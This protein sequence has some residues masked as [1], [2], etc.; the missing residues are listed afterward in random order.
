MN[1]LATLAEF[2]PSVASSIGYPSV[3]NLIV[4]VLA[5][6]VLF[7]VGSAGAKAL[8][9][10]V[11]PMPA[12]GLNQNGNNEIEN[13]EDIPFE[14]EDDDLDEFED[15]QPLL[16]NNPNPLNNHQNQNDLQE[17][18]D[19]DEGYQDAQP[20]PPPPDY[21]LSIWATDASGVSKEMRLEND[22]KNRLN[23]ALETIRIEAAAGHPELANEQVIHS[24]QVSDFQKRT[25]TYR[26]AEGLVVEID[27]SELC[28]RDGGNNPLDRAFFD[29]INLYKEIALKQRKE[30]L[31]RELKGTVE[32]REGVYYLRVN[33][34]DDR[35]LTA[36]EL[37]KIYGLDKTIELA[38]KRIASPQGLERISAQQATFQRMNNELIKTE[39]IKKSVFYKPLEK[40]K[41]IPTHLWNLPRNTY[42]AIRDCRQRKQPTAFE[43][44]TEAQKTARE[45]AETA[46]NHAVNDKI[47]DVLA[48]LVPDIDRV[49]L[50]ELNRIGR[51]VD[52][53]YE[54]QIAN[55]EK[56]KQLLAGSDQIKAAINE[57]MQEFIEQHHKRPTLQD[58]VAMTD[59]VYGRLDNA[60]K[61]T[62]YKAI[63]NKLDPARAIFP[64]L[65]DEAAYADELKHLIDDYFNLD[66][67]KIKAY[68]KLLPGQDLAQVRNQETEALKL[69]TLK[70]LLEDN[71]KKPE[72]ETKKREYLTP[73]F[74]K[75]VLAEWK[76]RGDAE[77]KKH[78]QLIN[79]QE[80]HG[81]LSRNPRLA[82]ELYSYKDSFDNARNTNNIAEWKRAA[83]ACYNDL[84]KLAPGQGQ[85]I[86]EL[87]GAYYGGLA[88]EQFV[89][90]KGLILRKEFK[91]D[92]GSITG[93][94][95][96]VGAA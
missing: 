81:I 67:A 51:E 77:Q 3:S 39:K 96:A 13:L 23:E 40:A 61:I 24:F 86:V 31:G 36:Q 4:G 45:N 35:R 66:K 5:L 15:V 55:K 87:I 37:G 79:S 28:L 44:F 32:N 71:V 8:M 90:E 70:Q 85:F 68:E 76:E 56:Y 19:G 12:Q 43:T 69:A 91:Q 58:E 34:M 60:R 7:Q 65:R 84:L 63:L 74:Q 47:N 29:V 52:E 73:I 30:D 14:D 92:L 25:V 75:E 10:R 53:Y 22:Q 94:V 93:L 21:K 80:L 18:D 41:K 62:A 59:E 27:L 38:N 64:Q 49:R 42:V 46:L 54:Y 2:P 48:A 1:G 50:D 72:K 26:N 57:K 78:A 33:G 16:V 83:E 11:A 88:Y 89:K 82:E 20:I 95:T 6:A 9:G 17:Q